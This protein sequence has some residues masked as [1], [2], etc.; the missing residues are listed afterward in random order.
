MNVELQH[1]KMQDTYR[2]MFSTMIC[3]IDKSGTN[4]WR[5][6]NLYCKPPFCP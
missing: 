3:F 4:W 1:H 5:H 6:E 2:V